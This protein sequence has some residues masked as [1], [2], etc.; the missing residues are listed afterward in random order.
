MYVNVCMLCRSEPPNARQHLCHEHAI[1]YKWLYGNIWWS[2]TDI[3][4]PFSFRYV[5]PWITQNLHMQTLGAMWRRLPTASIIARIGDRRLLASFGMRNR[6]PGSSWPDKPNW[7]SWRASGKW[8]K[9][10]TPAARRSSSGNTGPRVTGPI[11]RR[12]HG[13]LGTWDRVASQT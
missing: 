9:L 8:S 11:E 4:M 10:Q 13:L 12:R 6:D 2:I 3:S 5:P 7:W 1:W